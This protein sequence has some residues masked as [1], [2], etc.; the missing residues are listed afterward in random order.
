MAAPLVGIESCR[1]E[2]LAII[3]GRLRTSRGESGRALDLAIFSRLVWIIYISRLGCP[4]EPL[5]HHLRD[6]LFRSRLVLWFQSAI[7]T[8]LN[9]CHC[10]GKCSLGGVGADFGSCCRP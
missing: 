9:N 4:A 10:P 3:V 2:W 8:I 1:C 7:A 5:L 6:P